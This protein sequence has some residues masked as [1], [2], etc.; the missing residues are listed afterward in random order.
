MDVVDEQLDVIGKG[1]LGQTITCA[2]CH[3]HKFDPIPTKDYYALA[4]ILRNTKTLEHAN[5]SNGSKC[6]C[7]PTPK[8]KRRQEARGRGRRPARRNSRRLKAKLS[9][10]GGGS[11]IAAKSVLAI[12]DV[13]GIVVDD[14]K[15]M[16]VGEWKDSTY[17]GNLHRQRLHPRP[18]RRQGREDHHLP[19]RTARRRQ[20]RGPARLLAGRQSG[21]NVPVTVFSADGEKTV[22]RRHEEDTADRR[23][24]RLAGPVPASRR[25]GR[26]SC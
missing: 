25:T 24:L 9:A 13:P 11:Q 5:V 7:R 22:S 8:S 2:R 20:V 15:A 10:A 16:K 23:P 14:T 26:V 21:D 3:D 17:S 4:G 18:Q 12:K 19:A 1:F 6:R